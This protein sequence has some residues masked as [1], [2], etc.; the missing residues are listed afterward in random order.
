MLYLIPTA[1]SLSLLTLVSAQ[2]YGNS[3]KSSTSASAA[4]TTTASAVSGVHTIAVGQDG[5]TYTPNTLTANVGDQ[6][7]FN[8]ASSGHS[9]AESTFAAPCQPANGSAFWTGFPDSVML[10][11]RLRVEE[12]QID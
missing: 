5:L 9:V 11:R 6:V 8:F 3:G 2:N 4:A 1:V 10:S 12:V 7:Q